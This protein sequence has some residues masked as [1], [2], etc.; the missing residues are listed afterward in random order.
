MNKVPLN[1]ARKPLKNH[2]E[3]T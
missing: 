1:H 3:T 2:V